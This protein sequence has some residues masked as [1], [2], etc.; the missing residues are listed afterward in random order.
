MNAFLDARAIP[1]GTVLDTDIAIVGGGPT[2]IALALALAQTQM[3]V[4]LL[5]SGG[6]A[7][8][9]ATQA[10]YAGPESGV[11]YLPLDASRMR[12]LG[13]GT[14]HWGGWC[15][16][17]DLIDF[18]KRDGMPYSGWPIT[19]GALEPYFPRAQ[20]LVEAGTF[21]YDTA[22][23]LTDALGT[24]LALGAGGVGT[25][26]FQF[27]KM[28]GSMLPTHFG[29]RYADDLKRT[30]NLRLLT[31]A[32]AT[33]LRLAPDAK[34]VEHIDVATLSGRRFSIKPKIAVLGAG[35]IENAR[36]LLASNDVAQ[37]GIGNANGLV[38]RFFA[39]HPLP[40]NNATVVLFDGAIAPSY[41]GT[42]DA[43]DG[44]F[45]AAF[46]PSD[47]FRR[48]HRV[49]G[50]LITV[51]SGTKLDALGRASVAATAEALGISHRHAR[52]FVMG[53]GLEPR[54]DP[55]RRITLT[56]ER[57]ALGMPRAKLTMTLSDADLAGYRE[58]L[59]ELG[60]QLLT[61]RLGMLQI[62]HRTREGWLSSMDWGN[63]HMGTARMHNDP[64]QGAVDADLRVHGM[65]NLYVA[66]SSAFP[67]YGVSN[68]TMN[69]VALTLRLADHLKAQFR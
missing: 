20:Q 60:R 38:G 40:G 41:L 67:T 55:E 51:D 68:P 32:N 56:A 44:H 48:A 22:S 12:Y 14:N 18:E 59:R 16:P 69:L 26:Y 57:D 25:T 31:H 15:R 58:T 27:S 66:G 52:A 62:H 42:V 34:T 8:D 63:H 24:P 53:C 35:A 43:G 2:G 50:A 65:G 45:R 30:A 17:L 5:E 28:R 36:L 46:A 4:M 9:P 10:L 1:S 3:R 47:A 21:V 11:R 6:M 54:P 13:G 61:A 37:A 29:Q 23:R 33:G 64:K 39:D 49:P 7:F 19:R